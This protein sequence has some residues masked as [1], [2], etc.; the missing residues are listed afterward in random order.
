MTSPVRLG[1][2]PAATST[3]MGVFNQRFEALFP[4]ARALGCTICFAPLPALPVYLCVNVGL[5]GLLVV[6]VPAPFVPQS[7]SLQVRQ[8]CW[9]SYH[10]PLPISAPPT[11]LDE[12]SFFSSLVVGLLWS[13]TFCQFSLFSVFKLLLSFFWLCEEAQCVSLCLHLGFS[14]SHLGFRGGK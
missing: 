9:E 8:L 7:S 12:C 2:P 6:T 14:P 13:S 5:R 4:R 3:P 1:V 10:P 11:G